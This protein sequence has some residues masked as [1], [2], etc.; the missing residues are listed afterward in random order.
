MAEYVFKDLLEKNNLSNEFIVESAAISSDEIG[1]PVHYAARAELAKHG[2]DCYE[3]RAVKLLREDYY[4]YDYIL[5]MEQR[6]VADMLKYFGGD[7]CKKI[8]RLLDFSQNPRDIADPWYTHN[9]KITYQDVFEGC[10]CLLEY[11][12]KEKIFKVF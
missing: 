3:K 2:I 11:L 1:N 4:K 10:V 12:K 8:K 9:F 6:N 7:E 5:G